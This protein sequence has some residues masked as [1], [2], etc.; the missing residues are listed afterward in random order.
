VQLT[1]QAPPL[2]F[3]R[4]FAGVNRRGRPALE[5][6]AA[7]RVPSTIRRLGACRSSGCVCFSNCP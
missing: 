1:R 4:L 7:A 3:A 2:F 6:D 5:W